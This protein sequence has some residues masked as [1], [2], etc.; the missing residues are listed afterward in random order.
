MANP[1]SEAMGVVLERPTRKSDG[2]RNRYTAVDEIESTILSVEREIWDRKNALTERFE[3]IIEYCETNNRPN[4]AMLVA[5][6]RDECIDDSFGITG[7]PISVL[8]VNIGQIDTAYQDVN[9][10]TRMLDEI[11]WQILN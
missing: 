9:R 10:I 2:Y 8:E 5:L 6:L 1:I 4:E 3:S 11:E 7:L